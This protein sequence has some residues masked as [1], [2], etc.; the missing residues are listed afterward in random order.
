MAVADVWQAMMIAAEE[1]RLME[2]KELVAYSASQEIEEIQ[3]RRSAATNNV[4]FSK[5]QK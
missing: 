1:L 3:E 2:A 4:E 5:T